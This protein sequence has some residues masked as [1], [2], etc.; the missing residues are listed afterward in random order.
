MSARI[1]LAIVG[2]EARWLQYPVFLRVFSIV[3][4]W[5]CNPFHTVVRD[6]RLEGQA[7][8][9]RRCRRNIFTITTTPPLSRNEAD[10]ELCLQYP[11]ERSCPLTC[12]GSGVTKFELGRWMSHCVARHVLQI[13]RQFVPTSRDFVRYKVF[14]CAISIRN[15]SFQSDTRK[16]MSVCVLVELVMAEL[17]GVICSHAR[18][19][20]CHRDLQSYMSILKH[21]QR[22]T[23]MQC[24]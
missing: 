17:D 7:H 2:G 4:A 24:R 18:S 5:Y 13:S 3:V 20:W 10:K 1:C 15:C 8:K 23:R 9:T 22:S 19:P 12:S 16:V 6:R 11:L 14:H 21:C